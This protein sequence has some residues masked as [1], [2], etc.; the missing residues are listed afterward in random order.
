[1]EFNIVVVFYSYTMRCFCF[2]NKSLSGRLGK[3]IKK[4]KS[5]LNKNKSGYQF[6]NRSDDD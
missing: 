2:K 1:M 5:Y 4:V 3:T 6:V